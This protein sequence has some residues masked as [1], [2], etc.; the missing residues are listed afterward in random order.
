MGYTNV[1][2]YPGGKQ[3]WVESG[4]PVEGEARAHNS[5]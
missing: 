5:G 3:E 1:T 4:L 2:D